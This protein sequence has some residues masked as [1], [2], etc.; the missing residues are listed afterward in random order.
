MHVL[1]IFY[2]P[3]H[4]ISQTFN[5]QKKKKNVNKTGAAALKKAGLEL[6]MNFYIIKNLASMH[7]I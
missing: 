1:I 2:L 7:K 5:L 4:L 6:Q 3:S